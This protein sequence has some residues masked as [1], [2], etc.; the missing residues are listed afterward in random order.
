MYTELWGFVLVMFVAGF[1]PAYLLAVF[2]RV[3]MVSAE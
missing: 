3:A 2:R 1:V